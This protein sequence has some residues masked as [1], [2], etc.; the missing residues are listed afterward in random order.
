MRDILIVA[1]FFFVIYHSFRRPYIGVCAWIWIAMTAPTAWAFGF[2]TSL[3]MN[4][5]I[6]LVTFLSYLFAFKNKKFSIGGVGW[7]MIMFLLQAT[8]ST[9]AHNTLDGDHVFGYFT[10]HLK[11][12]LLFFFIALV[13]RTKTEII[14]FLWC[15]IFSVSAYAAMEGLKFILSGGSHEVIGRAGVVIDRND[16]AVAVNMSIPLI[17]FLISVTEHKWLKRGLFILAMLNV[18]AVIGTY[19]RGGFI[20]LCIIGIA[21]W[22]RSNHKVVLAIAALLLLPTIYLNTPDEWRERQSTVSTAATEDGSFI[23]RLWAWKISTLIALDDPMTGGGYRAVTD[24]LLW[25]YYG[26]FTPN[27]G[28]VETPPI[29]E[30]LLP[31]AAHNIYFQVLGDHGFIGLLLFL[32]ILA[33]CFFDNLRNIR[34]AKALGELWLANLCSAL[35]I[36]IIGYGITGLNV[37]LAYFDLSYAFFALVVVTG[38]YLKNRTNNHG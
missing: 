26:G 33:K 5:T 18:V 16:L 17:F 25:Q 15:I 7:L 21:A 10:E 30:E 19:S 3:R 14:T 13:L 32:C 23:G 24:P 35:N 9:M 27:F 34:K 8:I 4:L 29:P 2:S 31:K 37:S 38:N 36:G 22:L 12:A 11:T 6:V 1:L 28:P 20:G